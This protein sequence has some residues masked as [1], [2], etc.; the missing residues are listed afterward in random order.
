MAFSLLISE[1]KSQLEEQKAELSKRCQR[2]KEEDAAALAEE[3]KDYENN[4]AAEY[5]YFEFVN[6]IRLLSRELFTKVNPDSNG[7]AHI[8]AIL[9]ELREKLFTFN[10]HFT[11]RFLNTE[12]RSADHFEE[13]SALRHLATVKELFATHIALLWMSVKQIN[14]TLKGHTASSKELSILKTIQKSVQSLIVNK[15]FL[16]EIVLISLDGGNGQ[17]RFTLEEI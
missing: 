1:S 17:A 8:D 14:G 7:A 5:R 4:I 11:S 9:Y 12:L 15:A 13:W 6:T 16:E 2:K 10:E 3:E